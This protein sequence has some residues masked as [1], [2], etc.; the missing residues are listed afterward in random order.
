MSSALAAV[1]SDVHVSGTRSSL[2]LLGKDTAEST[3]FRCFASLLCAEMCVCMGGD[4]L[5]GSRIVSLRKRHKTLPLGHGR[6]NVIA[7]PNV[8]RA[9]SSRCPDLLCAHVR[10]V[11]VC[12]LLY[13]RVEA[14]GVV[15]ISF[16]LR[17]ESLWH[18]RQKKCAAKYSWSEPFHSTFWVLQWFL[19]L[20][21]LHDGVTNVFFFTLLQAY[22]R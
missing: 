8:I 5:L 22:K 10:L 14:S 20:S 19:S 1:G 11:C 21:A 4:A 2:W 18:S 6:M 17:T 16:I 3:E 15:F 12:F 13:F 7:H 9:D